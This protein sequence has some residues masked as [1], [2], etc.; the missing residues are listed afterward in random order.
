MK[1]LLTIILISL[2]SLGWSQVQD[3]LF[4]EE[5]LIKKVSYYQN[6]NIRET[7]YFDLSE[8]R[9]GKWTLYLENGNC[10]SIASF[11]HGLKHGEWVMYDDNGN[12][13]CRMF[14][15][16]GEKTGTWQLYKNGEL[17]Q[18]RIY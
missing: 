3:S 15:K 13:A 9:H 2:S 8:R 14:Y 5:D 12:I 4:L 16:N 11:N 7:G 17:A 10:V 18:Q 1:K 6:G